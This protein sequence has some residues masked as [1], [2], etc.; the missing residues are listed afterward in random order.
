MPA[1]HGGGGSFT[2]V[3]IRLCKLAARPERGLLADLADLAVRASQLPTTDKR[4][5]R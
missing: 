2:D 1:P 4:R 3:Y 5:V